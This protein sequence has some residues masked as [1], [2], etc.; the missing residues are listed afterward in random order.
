MIDPSEKIKIIELSEY[1]SE[2]PLMYT[3]AS[4]EIKSI[5]L[6]NCL[7]VHHIGST[8]IPNIYA[9][10]IIDVLPIVKDIQ[11]GRFIKS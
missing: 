4:I 1:N 8:A 7:E 11:P 5:L 3:N 10:P 9:K 2:W 6:D